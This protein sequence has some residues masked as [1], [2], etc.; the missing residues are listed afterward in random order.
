MLYLNEFCT[1]GTYSRYSLPR[2]HQNSTYKIHLVKA[3]DPAY[4]PSDLETW[5][6]FYQA[7]LQVLRQHPAAHDAAI[8]AIRETRKDLAGL[9]NRDV[10][11]GSM[12]L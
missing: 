1:S 12:P 11:P 10:P 6:I 4:I 8:Q 5:P 7:I 3:N 2:P 9:D